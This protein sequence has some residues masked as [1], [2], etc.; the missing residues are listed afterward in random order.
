MLAPV[1]APVAAAGDRDT[2]MVVRALSGDAVRDVL[3]TLT[4]RN[5]GLVERALADCADT[6]DPVGADAT[7][8]QES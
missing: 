1:A 6:W 5:P 2:G 3:L 4:D 8:A 7:A